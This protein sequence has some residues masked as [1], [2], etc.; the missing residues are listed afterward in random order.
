MATPT[1]ARKSKAT[2]KKQPPKKK[3]LSRPSHLPL[4]PMLAAPPLLTLTV[5]IL[6]TSEN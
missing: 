2:S 3:I 4:S 1:K 6:L 5:R